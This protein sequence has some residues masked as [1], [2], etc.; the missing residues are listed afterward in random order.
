MKRHV[1]RTSVELP[2]PRDRVFLFFAD[3]ANLEV[4]TPPEF[5]GDVT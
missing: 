1:F 4:I 5:A 2:L 3:A